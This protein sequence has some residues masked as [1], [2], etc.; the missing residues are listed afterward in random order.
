MSSK[1]IRKSTMANTI[2]MV[3]LLTGFLS[4]ITLIGPISVG[5]A[6]IK[7][8]EVAYENGDYPTA[9][10]EF[11][12]AAEQGH[13][14]AQRKLA[15]MYE[16]GRGVDQDEQEAM[17]WYRKA[18]EQGDANALRALGMAPK[19]QNVAMYEQKAQKAKKKE[20]ERIRSNTFNSSTTAGKIA[21]DGRFIAY[22]NGTVLDTSTNLI[23][24]AKDNV[25]RIN[26]A[27]AK[28]YCES[29]RGG[30]YTD[31]RLPTQDELEGLYD[32][33]V[34]GKYGYH[35]TNL[36]ELNDCC[37]WASETLRDEAAYFRFDNGTRGVTFQSYKGINTLALP[38]RSKIIS[39]A[40]QT[41]QEKE[42]TSKKDKKK[43]KSGTNDSPSP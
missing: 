6:G 18:A 20:F 39:P 40:N 34:K 28:S 3:I 21:K 13:P 31:W 26:W 41:T 17:K 5:N 23:W 7:E 30:G 9:L 2:S 11:S 22:D 43:K 38:V 15:W 27:H 4:A 33:A 42:N 12:K 25:G 8:G 24:A 10:R 36:I 16:N 35:L 29:Y 14:I 37:P 1:D 19:G 32:G